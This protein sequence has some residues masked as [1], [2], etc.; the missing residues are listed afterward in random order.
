[1]H[2]SRCVPGF[3]RALVNRFVLQVALGA[4]LVVGIIAL[5]VACASSPR[6]TEDIGS[7]SSALVFT[8]L[9]PTGVD[10]TGA[11]LAVGATDPHYVL[12]SDDPLR[13]GPTAL[14][15]SAAA[16]WITNT[17]TSNWISAQA[18]A[19]GASG[20][21]Y[22]YTT[23]FTLAGV[24]PTLVAISG[25]W[26]CAD[27]CAVALNGTMIA[28]YGAPAGAAVAA[29]TIPEGSPFVV[30]TNTLTFVTTDSSGGVTGLHVIS[31]SG[32]ASGCTSDRQCSTAQFCNTQTTSCVAK[33]PSGTPIPTISGHT[34]VLDGVCD[35]GV[36]ASVCA[37]GVCDQSN[38]ECGLANGNGPCTA[39]NGAILCQSGACSVNGTC[40]P[41]GGCNVDGDCTA[42][43][44]CDVGTH[45][46]VALSDGSADAS[47][48]DAGEGGGVEAGEAEGGDAG[49]DGG[50][51]ADG[52]QDGTVGADGSEG[53]D[54][55]AVAEG[56]TD[57]SAVADGPG[58][59]AGA[60]ED[61]SSVEDGSATEDG[62]AKDAG[63]KDAMVRAER[64]AGEEGADAGLG[65][66][67]VLEGDGLSCSSARAGRGA[68]SGLPIAVA[69][70]AIAA[71]MGRRRRDR[72]RKSERPARPSA[73]DHR[74]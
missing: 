71:A 44:Q 29:F 62:S 33:L 11:P 45:Q 50:S 24:D 18:D 21:H 14:V 9:F 72:T 13:P 26:A 57:A 6:G 16:G 70:L 23:T 67:K 8:G 43:Q 22:T 15:V 53:D 32:R 61:G 28:S 10:A 42:A 20:G 49:L 58:T 48:A 56:S 55:A 46:C 30:G 12:T 38:N 39:S 52:S 41:Q 73:G 69:G 54:G 74:E 60:T 27:S 34:P 59:D 2:S 37:A 68:P 7:T 25:L 19:T 1:M 5:L 31:M 35:T 3:R 47:G 4:V 40:E 63:E 17:S 51:G 66:N 64:E 36:G 65:P